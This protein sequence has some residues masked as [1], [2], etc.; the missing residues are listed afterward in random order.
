MADGFRSKSEKL[1]KLNWFI[2]TTYYSTIC[3]FSLK[4]HSFTTEV[5]SFYILLLDYQVGTEKIESE[6]D[7]F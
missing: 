3:C 1:Y 5:R 6:Y 4:K 7:F 2:F